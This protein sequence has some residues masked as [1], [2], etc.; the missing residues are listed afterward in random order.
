MDKLPVYRIKINE[1]LNSNEGIDFVS[2]VDYPAIE[3]NWIA[4]SK[5]PQKFFFD[6][7]KQMLY[8]AILIPDKKIYRFSEDMGEYWVEF[9]EGEVIKLVR[10]LQAQKK[11]VNLNYQHKKD[12]QLSNAVIQ[13]IWLTGKSDKSKDFGFDFPVNTAMVGVHIGDAKFWNDEVKTG[14][15]KGFSIE[16]WLDMELAMIKNKTR[17]CTLGAIQKY[18]IVKRAANNDLYISGEVKVGNYVYYNQPQ[19]VLIGEQQQELRTPIWENDV[20][21]A[22]GRVLV[23]ECGKIIQIVEASAA[24][25]HKKNKQK[26]SKQNFAEAKTKDGLY[27]IKTADEK[28]IVGS[29]VV[30]VDADGKEETTKDGDHEMENGMVITVKDGKVTELKDVT[31]A[32][33]ELDQEATEVIQKAMEP[34]IAKMQKNFDEKLAAL[35]VEFTNQP[36]GPPKKKETPA[37]TQL[38]AVEKVKKLITKK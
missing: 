7:D 29:A 23:L 17:K 35:K 12:S 18:D 6:Q 11:S 25:L 37:P 32:D 27:T 21:L 4:M 20:E 8:G 24:A 16:G 38:S 9:P 33:E 22:D 14:N 19:I 36:G 31:P 13:E 26:M 30:T 28:M 10:K 2:L 5:A 34:I 3:S 15:V 1:D